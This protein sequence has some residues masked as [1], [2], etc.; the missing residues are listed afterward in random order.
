MV[1]QYMRPFLFVLCLL[2][3]LAAHAQSAALTDGLA[4]KG[5]IPLQLPSFEDKTYSGSVRQAQAQFTRF[6]DQKDI[7]AVDRLLP[8]G[9]QGAMTWLALNVTNN[10]ASDKWHI[11]VEPQ[12]RFG[13][14]PIKSLRVYD[15][16]L[17]ETYFT[18]WPQ[19][20]S[21]GYGATATVPIILPRGISSTRYLMVETW[22][23][24]KADVLPILK[25]D[26]AVVAEKQTHTRKMSLLL[27][28]VGFMCG[29]GLIQL[30]LT[31]QPLQIGLLLNALIIGGG[32]FMLGQPHLLA[33][34]GFEHGLLPTLLFSAALG[35]GAALL[36]WLAG[37]SLKVPQGMALAVATLNL[38]VL[39][40]GFTMLPQL[41]SMGLPLH[42]L[43]H[44]LQ[45]LSG[46]ILLGL[47]L[48]AAMSLTSFAWFLPAW[49]VL[50]LAPWLANSY[51]FAAY[52]S[53][54]ALLLIASVAAVF[55]YWQNMARETVA[56]QRRL[57]QELKYIKEKSE[58]ENRDWQQKMDGE[59]VLLNELK[60][61]EQQRAAEL[62]VARREAESANK[63]KS[64]FLAIIS[65]EIRTP[66]NGIMGIVQL[67]HQTPM[68]EKQLE[69]VDVI[70]N[71][72]DTM[73]T[74]LN[75]IL[76]YSKIE[77]GAIEIENIPMT[78][79]SLIQSV[80]TL[81]LGRA[82]DKGIDLVIDVD[83]TIPDHLIGDPNRLR[84]ILLNLVSNGIKFTESGS[85][86]IKVE[87]KK[88]DK[89]NTTLHFGVIDTGMGIPPEVQSKL[90]QPYVQADASI[91]RRFGGTGLG[92]NICR[93]L[94]AAMDGEIGL[95][96]EPGHGSTFWFD[97]T[98]EVAPD[99]IAIK[100]VS[101]ENYQPSRML[102]VLAIDDNGVN[103]KVVSGLLE[104]DGHTVTTTTQA[105]HGLKLIYD[106]VF[107]L[108]FVDLL[109]P[110]MDGKTFAM[111]V[112]Q[113]PNQFIARTPIYALTG[114]GGDIGRQAAQASG[115]QGVL[116]KP[117]TQQGLRA[118]IESV[119][120]NLTAK[121]QD[122]E[123]ALKDLIN[124]LG[125][126]APID[127]EKL[128][129]VLKEGTQGVKDLYE[130]VRHEVKLNMNAETLPPEEA[131]P[132]TAPEQPKSNVVP[133]LNLSALND[134]KNSLPEATLQGLFS[135]L[136]IKAKE[137]TTQM[138]EAT[139][140]KDID[141]LGEKAH[142]LKG[143]CGNFGLEAMSHL[144]GKIEHLARGKDSIRAFDLVPKV[145]PLLART[146]TEL[147][148]WSK[149]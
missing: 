122:P 100:T 76:D 90:F 93:M 38:L 124:K 64:D 4:Q 120:K 27:I 84:Q 45:S 96:S 24:L 21:D 31:K 77:K 83:Q 66:M 110:G 112:R 101:V 25:S 135:E 52:I 149:N 97:L 69:Y 145:K 139:E 3:P 147:E 53:Y 70:K 65:H 55:S 148:N 7:F 131:P 44:M 23:G 43:P 130:A 16:A 62:D 103:L 68:N 28:I 37:Q 15:P 105:E 5:S 48:V 114:M 56:L 26:Q 91:S 134:L 118:I 146:L 36:Q 142:N 141:D 107:D 11:A 6:A 34:F 32:F 29:A 138:E 14:S 41:V 136:V 39:A 54:G 46:V 117:V 102:N 140:A 85:V 132:T 116:T 133:Y 72:G 89:N 18:A 95:T 88:A 109:M 125:A 58:S 78:L 75:D 17:P 104:M 33:S 50:T 144:C 126:L 60:A 61:R 98:F 1:S 71:S 42:Y 49:L 82:K 10:S 111:K 57:K 59:R 86:T 74:L 30:I 63:A 8:L 73:L 113:H 137:L 121:E 128:A 94:V 87:Q 127:R 22:P 81:M 79:R 12:G 19:A 80:A 129:Q 106:K 51:P 9:P 47:A 119:A 143:M 40:A 13:V 67:M 115:M 35:I 99:D 20:I 92:L 2:W 123:M 108:V